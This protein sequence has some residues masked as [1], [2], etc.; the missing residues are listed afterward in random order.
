VPQSS[1][2]ARRRLAYSGTSSTRT[3]RCANPTCRA[4]LGVDHTTVVTTTHVRRFCGI[5]CVASGYQAEIHKRAFVDIVTGDALD[6]G[7]PF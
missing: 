5:E 7:W 4:L 3:F 2:A 1:A 6:D